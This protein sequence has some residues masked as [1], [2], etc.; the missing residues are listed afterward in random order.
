VRPAPPRSSL[1]LEQAIRARVAE[2]AGSWFPDVGLRPDVRLRA[3]VERPRAALYAVHLGD[4]EQPRVLAKVRR[5]WPGGK[6]GGWAGSRP[7]LVSQ[8]LPAAEQ[9]ALEHSGLR[10][11]YGMVE[12]ADPRF[13][14]VRPLDHLIEYD[15]LLMEYVA[16][17]TLRTLFAA[18]SRLT[19]RRGS[20]ARSVPGD[21]WGRVGAWLRLFQEKV[22][23][24]GLPQR[25]AT[26]E[27]VVER[28]GAYADFFSARRGGGAIRDVARQ[29]AQLAA[30]VLPERLALAVGHGD[31]A[32]RNVFVHD[33]GRIAVFDPLPRWA[34]PRLDDLCRFLVSI[35][36]PGI[37]VHSHGA[38]Y[39]RAGLDRREAQ[40]IAGFGA[41]DLDMAE[42]R[43]LQLLLTLDTWSSVVDGSPMSWGGRL[44]SA[45]AG[46]AAGHVRSETLRLLDLARTAGG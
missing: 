4:A 34:A 26:R 19:L 39:G 20:S 44:R 24:N 12:P 14:A 13:R 43:C 29:G 1:T 37:Q 6:E 45:S 10:A 33:D 5:G 22:P 23:A 27:E 35:R 3:L 25:Q 42:L 17:P 41:T 18:E 16:A 9:V 11:I 38:A 28:F 46:R 31:F 2:R 7:R 8:P 36:L 21:V 30:D 32:P 15:V 40:V